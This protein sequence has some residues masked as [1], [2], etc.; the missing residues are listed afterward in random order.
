MLIFNIAGAQGLGA[1]DELPK[2]V[3]WEVLCRA[4]RPGGE[5]YGVLDVEWCAK[6]MNLFVSML[7]LMT[8]YSCRVV[9]SVG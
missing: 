5:C 1:V 8:I 2:D 6:H 7:T 9:F 4:H 3:T